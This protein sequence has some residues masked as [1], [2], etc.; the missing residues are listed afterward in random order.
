MK[1]TNRTDQLGRATRILQNQ[2][3]GKRKSAGRAQ[4]KKAPLKKWALPWCAA[5]IY[6]LQVLVEHPQVE[7]LG[8]CSLSR[9][10]LARVD[11]GQLRQ[12]RDARGAGLVRE[13][14]GGI[15]QTNFAD[16]WR[17]REGEGGRSAKT[18]CV[19]GE[20]DATTIAD[21]L[22]AGH[23]LEI[24]RMRERRRR[25]RRER[26][27][28]IA[29]PMAGRTRLTKQR[30]ATFPT[31]DAPSPEVIGLLLNRSDRR[32]GS[33]ARRSTAPQSSIRLPLSEIASSVAKG[34]GLADGDDSPTSSPS[35]PFL[36]HP[37]PRRAAASPASIWSPEA[38][39]GLSS[40]LTAAAIVDVGVE[41]MLST[42]A[43]RLWLS[44]MV[45]S[46]GRV[47]KHD[48]WPFS[49]PSRGSKEISHTVIVR[50]WG[51]KATEPQPTKRAQRSLMYEEPRNLPA[52]WR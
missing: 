18:A 4:S 23:S 42:S 48:T 26:E 2:Q 3:S 22:L 47:E 25:R 7:L 29:E 6:L 37:P 46:T 32:D 52:G 27:K 13:R 24:E 14:G 41:A 33:P 49:A 19:R 44:R 36:P 45:A 21:K 28:K 15:G 20:S 12:S 5:V 10:D 34:G 16:K 8:V 1:L 40:A 11:P 43:I 9:P 39:P 30:T 17:E 35:S 50:G 31:S 38:G 51:A